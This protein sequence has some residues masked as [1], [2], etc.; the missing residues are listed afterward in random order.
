LKAAS[1][2]ADLI[3]VLDDGS[4]DNTVEIVKRFSKVKLKIQHKTFNEKRDREFIYNWAKR[5]G[6]TWIATCDGDEVFDDRMTK[7]YAN[8]LMHPKNP[9]VKAYVFRVVTFWRG[10]KNIRVDSTFNNL[11]FNR[12]YKVEPNQH[13]RCEHP[14]GL[15][16]THAPE[17]P[18][19]NLAWCP[20]RILH[21]G[22]EK[23][24]DVQ[25]KFEWYQKTDQD[26]RPELI[27]GADYSHLIDE[28]SLMLRE[29]QTHNKLG[30][31]TMV[32]DEENLLWQF[33]D[34]TYSLF[35]E[36]VFVVDS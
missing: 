27:G 12:M 8:W 23:F 1:K 25:R 36:L 7:E 21:Y 20:V 17:F 31:V 2:F 22:Y 28:S 30:L 4:T 3:V 15:H 14:Q 32:R 10:R 19:E 9:M 33:L 26:K 5:E 35:D 24:S 16:M 29:F 6:A 34:R 18:L 11:A 13:F